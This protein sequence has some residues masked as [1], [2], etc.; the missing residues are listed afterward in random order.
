MWKTG[1]NKR[2]KTNGVDDGSAVG[3]A[4]AREEGGGLL[5]S[6]SVTGLG[7]SGKTKKRGR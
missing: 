3:A 7:A 1:Q 6:L 2:K 4:A 5:P